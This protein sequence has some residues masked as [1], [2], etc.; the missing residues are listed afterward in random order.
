MNEIDE[1]VSRHDGWSG[2]IETIDHEIRRN[3]IDRAD[4]QGDEPSSIPAL[5]AGLL[6]GPDA[7][8]MGANVGRN[9]KEARILPA[10]GWT[11]ASAAT[12]RVHSAY[13]ALA[14][15]RRTLDANG[16]ASTRRSASSRVSTDRIE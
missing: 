1:R 16:L 7:P 2:L 14:S 5:D 4:P 10:L 13:I 9:S 11:S 12:L 6:S 8:Q 15:Y 3:G